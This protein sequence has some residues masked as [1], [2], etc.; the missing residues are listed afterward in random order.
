MNK[1]LFSDLQL[2]LND[3][4]VI[5]DTNISEKVFFTGLNSLLNASNTELTFFHNTKYLDL[6]STTKAKACFIKNEFKN[7]LPK[8]CLPIIVE[9]PYF[10]FALTTNYFY[11]KEISNKIISSNTIINNNVTLGKDIQINS[12]V[13]INENTMIA[14]E[15]IILQNSVIGPNVKIDTGTTIMSNCVI[16]DSIIGKNCVIQNGAIIGGKGFGFTPDTK[17]EIRHIGGV[18]I[19]NNVD[20]GS[21]STIDRG[22]LD[23]TFIGNNV[24][25]DNL[26]QIAHNVIIGDNSIIAAQSG[27]AG[28]TKIGKNCIIGGQSGISGHLVIGNNVKIAGKSGVTKNIKDNS[29]VAGF[30]ARDIKIWKKNIINQFKNIK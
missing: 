30:P 20:I 11:P 15:C 9:N 17:I 7:N 2:F 23:S 16:T 14:D 25:I 22:T 27:I 5:V 3:N 29:V 6:L 4:N 21:N 28:S 10:V 1:K 13:T 8:S 19:G 26:V 18:I 12:N 24:R